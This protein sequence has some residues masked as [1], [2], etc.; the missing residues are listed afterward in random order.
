MRHNKIS[1]SRQCAEYNKRKAATIPT[2]SW[3]LHLLPKIQKMFEIISLCPYLAQFLREI[4]FL[5]FLGLHLALAQHNQDLLFILFSRSW[6]TWR[7]GQNKRLIFLAKKSQIS[8][9]LGKEQPETQFSLL[10]R[11]RRMVNGLA[12]Y[13]N[14]TR[15]E[16]VKNLTLRTK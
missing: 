7:N 12:N 10:L 5:P 8:L 15:K 1:Q 14:A 3:I 11:Y 4:P 6:A 9:N 13:A 2:T 16:Y